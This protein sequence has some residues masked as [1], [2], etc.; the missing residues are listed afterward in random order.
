MNEMNQSQLLLQNIKAV[1]RGITEA[2]A[3]LSAQEIRKLSAQQFQS[4]FND[5]KVQ[6]KG[7]EYLPYERGS[8][9]IYNHLNNHPSLVAADH[10]QITLDSHYISGLLYKY[11]KN[12]GIRVARHSLA[13]ESNHKAY[14]DRFDYIRVYSKNFIP[15]HLTKKGVKKENK[16]FYKRAAAALENNTSIVFS[17]EGLSYETEAS[18]GPF[19]K[20][21]FKL[22]CGMKK[23]PKIVPLVMVDFDKL[24]HNAAYKCQ[25]MPSFTMADYG[26][27]DPNDPRL[28]EVVEKIN[29]KYKNWVQKLRVKEE[30]F[31]REI[32]VLKRKVDQIETQEAQTVFYGSS[33]I[34]LWKNMAQDLAPH[35]TLNLGFGGAFIHSLSH[36]FEHLFDGLAP[37]NIMLYLGGN[38]LTLGFDADR[39]VVDITSF[40][41]MIHNKFPETNIYNIAIKP[42]FERESELSEILGINA[43]VQALSDKLPYLHQLGLYEKLMDDNRIR[44]DVFLQ[45]GLHLNEKGYK[46][47]TALVLAALERKQ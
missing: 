35:Q 8:I 34:R 11:Y 24:P 42:S 15:D 20:G 38:D 30:H 23:Q 10:F 17:P 41:Q 46:A 44:K 32:A 4:I 29:K 1:F 28:G 12:P 9:F 40:V 21:V 45:D 47:L 16:N 27:Y 18:P 26:I 19:S 37:Q 5:L 25:I 2:P 3:N 33:T 6:I 43:G 36:Y 13:S 39:I 31:E 14:Y 22:A 7:S